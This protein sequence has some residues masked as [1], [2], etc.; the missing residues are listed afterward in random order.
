MNIYSKSLFDIFTKNNTLFVFLFLFLLSF[1]FLGIE[2]AHAEI[3]PCGIGDG[4]PCTFCHLY[5]LL[6]NVIDFLLII[7]IP[8]ALVGI[9]IGAFYILTSGGNTAWVSTGKGIIGSAIMGILI[10]LLAWLIINTILSI[11][12]YKGDWIGF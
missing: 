9:A 1:F 6:R 8:L 12:G 2:Y 3:I 7:I 10:T 11:L 4:V 5:D